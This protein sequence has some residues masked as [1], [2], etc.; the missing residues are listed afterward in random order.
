M[1]ML[2]LFGESAARPATLRGLAP[3]VTTQP[4][5]VTVLEF[6]PGRPERS[7]HPGVFHPAADFAKSPVEPG[8][9]GRE[10]CSLGAE[11]VPR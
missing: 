7:Y 2:L 9:N 6:P 11:N 1:F 3:E 8:R 5:T 4:V 10:A